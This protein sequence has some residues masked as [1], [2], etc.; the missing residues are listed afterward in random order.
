M[1]ITEF[2]SI[3]GVPLYRDD[4]GAVCFRAGFMIN[5]DGSPHAYAPEGSGLP[6]L[7]YLGNAGSPG[8]WWGIATDSWGKPYLQAAWHPAPGFYVSTTALCDSA[9][10]A[11]HP[12]RYVDSERYSFCVIPGGTNFAKLG[13]VGLAYNQTSGDNMYFAV[14]DIG[15]KTKIGEGSMLLARC[16]GLNSDPKKGGAEQRIINYVILPGSDP[17]YRPW[18]PKCKKAIELVDAWGGIARLKELSKLM[19]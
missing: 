3:A 16:L 5:A 7:D 12:S 13:D 19:A 10:P 14:G 11:D 8:N 4:K 2:L 6:A 15:P 9:F 1:N 17:G 18:E